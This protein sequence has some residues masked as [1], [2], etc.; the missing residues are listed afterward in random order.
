MTQETDLGSATPGAPP[1]GSP[2]RAARLEPQT[3]SILPTAAPV[4]RAGEGPRGLGR[5]RALLLVGGAAAALLCAAGGALVLGLHPATTDR[6][7]TAASDIS[8]DAGTRNPANALL[9]EG[10]GSPDL[11]PRTE[12]AATPA[13][14]T[15]APATPTEPSLADPPADGG[16][17]S[18]PAP[19]DG[20]T[21]GGTA[22]EPGTPST[23][24]TPSGPGAPSQPTPVPAAPKP[25]AFAGLTRNA[26]I[27]LLGIRILSSDTLS[28][29][30]QPGAT[31]SVSYG[32]SPAG[33]VTF[34][35]SG[36]ATLTVGG[37]LIDL[38]DPVIAVAYS[39]GTA[40]T[41]IRARRSAL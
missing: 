17:S 4:A 31:A 21:P 29:S 32:S 38:G 1:A 2:R 35:G 19:G 20:T 23:P 12:P 33:S 34:D 8:V 3:T 22:P 26:T 6:P 5:R 15:P 9:G 27:G 37:S 16:T 39:D 25:L 14:A 13:P 24:S 10:G 40:G 41:A 7:A 36:H 30:G 28:L 18:G 11:L